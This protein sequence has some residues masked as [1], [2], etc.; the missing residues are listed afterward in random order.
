[1]S[2]YLRHGASVFT[3]W[4]MILDQTATSPWGWRQN[5]LITIDTE[6][7]TVE[8]HP[9]FYLMKHLCH[10]VQPGAH[11][12]LTPPDNGHVLAFEN[13]D[14]KVVVVL[15]NITD[16]PMPLALEHK[17]RFLNVELCPHSFNTITF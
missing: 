5:S 12:L 1:M 8:Y 13:P 6:R 2:H 3:Y 17:G 16:Q 14:G 4:N 7:K 11:R 15:V 10:S 9:E